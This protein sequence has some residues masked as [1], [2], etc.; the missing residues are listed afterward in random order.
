MTTKKLATPAA[1]AE[2]VVAGPPSSDGAHWTYRP[3]EGEFPATDGP[4]VEQ[5][6]VGVPE[7]E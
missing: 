6:F 5:V 4:H 7:A 1:A 3:A 2:P